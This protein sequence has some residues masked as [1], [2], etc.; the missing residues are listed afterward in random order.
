MKYMCTDATPGSGLCD[1]TGATTRADCDGA[2]GDSTNCLWTV[3]EGT[4]VQKTI[5]VTVTRPADLTEFGGEW[6]KSYPKDSWQNVTNEY[7]PYTF[8]DY[9]SKIPL[10]QFRAVTINAQTGQ[11]LHDNA[12]DATELNVFMQM[13]EDGDYEIR[14]GNPHLSYAH[15]PDVHGVSEAGWERLGILQQHKKE[16]AAI[17]DETTCN[18]RALDD[19]TTCTWCDVTCTKPSGTYAGGAGCHVATP[20]EKRRWVAVEFKKS[21]LRVGSPWSQCGDGAAIDGASDYTQIGTIIP[22]YLG[23][24]SLLIASYMGIRDTLTATYT[25]DAATLKTKII[26]NIFTPTADSKGNDWHPSGWTDGGKSKFTKHCD[27]SWQEGDAVD[28]NPACVNNTYDKCYSAGEPCPLDHSVCKKEYCELQRWREIIKLYKSIGS[29][30]QVLGLV[31][32]KKIDNDP[33]NVDTYGLPIPRTEEEI[34]ADMDAY[35]TRVGG[36]DGID[37]F[38]MNE[39]HGTKATVDELMVIMNSYRGSYPN[40]FNVFGH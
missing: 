39:A 12:P 23:N 13:S 32:T 34:K 2:N 19:I 14:Y 4:C 6:V 26:L 20:M 24:P 10:D 3:G 36:A 37:G 38:Y 22:V 17:T 15:D 7:E 18:D 31:E 27:R 9:G 5:K 30:V 21:Q 40:L 25:G 35:L 33:D 1:N 11:K 16:C 28:G 29:H 8:N